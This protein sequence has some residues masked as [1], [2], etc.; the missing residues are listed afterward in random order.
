[1]KQIERYYRK[2]KR[3][4]EK[5]GALENIKVY[6]KVLLGMK[7][8]TMEELEKRHQSQMA[9]LHLVC[10]IEKLLFEQNPYETKQNL[11]E[12]KVIQAWLDYYGLTINYL[13]KE[14]IDILLE[15]MKK[16]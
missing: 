4:E 3:Y 9:R 5:K 1:M 13:T 11:K 12:N 6:L 2:I 8:E 7:A 14:D 15:I 16:I 10:L